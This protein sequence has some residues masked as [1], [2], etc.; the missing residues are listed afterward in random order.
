MVEMIKAPPT[1]MGFVAELLHRY[2]VRFL[3]RGE[4]FPEGPLRGEKLWEEGDMA[5]Y[6]EGPPPPPATQE[7]LRLLLRAFREVWELREREL[8]LLQS[9]EGGSRLL[10]LLLHE[11]KNSL[12]SVLGALELTLG[13][14]GLPDEAKELLVIAEKSAQRIQELL[15]KAQEYLRLG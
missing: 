2:P 13:T 15:Q 10:R 3:F 8:A 9:Q 6:W 5:L 12:M 1:D 14:E 4:V 7:A 11:I